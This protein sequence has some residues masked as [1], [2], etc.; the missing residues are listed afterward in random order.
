LTLLEVV[1]RL[2]ALIVVFLVF[3]VAAPAFAS[4]DPE[5]FRQ[6]GMEKI[7]A[8]AAWQKGRG[9]GVVIGIVDTGVDLDHPD[10]VAR[11]AGGTNLCG[12]GAPQDDDGHGSHV[13]GIAAATT[14][15]EVGVAGVAGDAKIIAAK[16]FGHDDECPRMADGIRWAADNG[17]HVINMSAGEHDRALGDVSEDAFG[18]PFREAVEYAWNQKGVVVVLSAGNQFLLS[19]GYQEIPALVVASTT[20]QDAKSDFSSGVGQAK[21][22]ISAPGGGNTADPSQEHI[23]STY[24]N[25]YRYLAGTSLAAPHV[26]GAA[27][28]LRGLGLSPQ[29]TVDRLLATAQDLG[30]TGKDSTFGYGRLDL[31]KAVQ[32]L[33]GGGGSSSSAGGGSAA[34]PGQTASRRRPPAGS[35]SQSPSASAADTGQTTAAE[36]TDDSASGEDPSAV[37]PDVEQR[38]GVNWFA[39]GL[40]LLVVGLATFFGTRFLIRRS[41]N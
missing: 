24:L 35:K 36:S 21:W 13:A 6:W 41:A 20:R 3:L 27:A 11:I 38:R 15:N 14:E 39:V 18:P 4:N 40:I 19:S 32:G 33:G 12:G 37:S 10:L 31:G 28:V 8:P 5:Y 22:G 29:A 2:P 7:G 1:R 17:A 34:G 30:S 26:S 25:G 16:V 9:A 23:Y